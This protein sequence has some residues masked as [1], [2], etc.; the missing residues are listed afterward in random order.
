MYKDLGSHCYCLR[1]TLP[2]SK[3]MSLITF[4]HG[5]VTATAATVNPNLYNS[6]YICSSFSCHVFVR[7]CHVQGPAQK[8]C[9]DRCAVKPV[10][11]NEGVVRVPVLTSWFDGAG[12]ASWL[13]KNIN[14]KRH[15]TNISVRKLSSMKKLFVVLY[16]WHHHIVCPGVP[17]TICSAYS[18]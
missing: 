6:Q 11:M 3:R 10:Q 15:M 14:G 18:R 2:P 17:P 16:K 12:A 5:K 8:R 7:K 1:L 4:Y 9:V 13:F